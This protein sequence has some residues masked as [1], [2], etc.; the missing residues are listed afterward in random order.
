MSLK[1]PLFCTVHQILCST[2]LAYV[3]I[4]TKRASQSRQCLMEPRPCSSMTNPVVNCLFSVILVQEKQRSYCNWLWYCS[5][6]LCR[7]SLLQCLS[8]LTFLRGQTRTSP[9]RIGSLKKLREPIRSH[10]LLSPNGS[11]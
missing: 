3:F 7:M 10:V 1:F 6:E 8:L 2:Q 11:K 5:N 4:F 9:C